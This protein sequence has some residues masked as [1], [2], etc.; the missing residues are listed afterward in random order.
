MSEAVKRGYRS[1][2][3]TAQ[4]RETRQAIVSAAARL[5]EETG[6]GATTIDAVAQAAGVSRKTV[7]TAVGG[8]VALLQTA[9]EWAVAGDDK[10]VALAER[11]PLRTLLGGRD[12]GALIEGW[13]R[14]LVEVDGR[15]APLYRALESAAEA[16]DEA[17][18]L[19]EQVRSQRLDGAQR[20][21]EALAGMGALGTRVTQSEA[22]DLAWLAADPLLFDRLAGQ[23]GWTADRVGRWLSASLGVWLLER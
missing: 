8:K 18:A 4:A 14:M 16:D 6:Y 19:L 5:F 17:R 9:L 15:V 21:I 11:E 22:V 23:R 2:L 20:I 7:F 12:S 1:A 10:P 13:A 3:R